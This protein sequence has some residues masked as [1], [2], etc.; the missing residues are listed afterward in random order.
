MRKVMM[1]AAV[2][3]MVLAAAPGFRPGDGRR[4]Q[5]PVRGL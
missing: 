1:L 2:M 3:A 5:R 4:R